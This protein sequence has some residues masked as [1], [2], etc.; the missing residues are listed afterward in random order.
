M[1]QEGHLGFR[2]LA[3]LGFTVLAGVVVLPHPA[4]VAQQGITAGWAVALLSA[5]WAGILTLP[6]VSLMQDFPGRGLPEALQE[7]FGL[8]P[9][10]VA[11][12]ALT[13]WL[14][15][16]T[17]LGVRLVM[18]TFAVA[19]LPRTPPTAIGA[20]VLAM[21]VYGAYLGLEPV[22][23]A[24]VIVWPALTLSVLAVAAAVLPEAHTDWLFPLAGPGLSGLV[25]ASLRDIGLWADLGLTGVYAYAARSPGHLRAAAM[26]ALATSAIALA[27]TVALGT[28]VLGPEDAARHPFLFYRLARLVYLGRFFQRAE[29]LFVLFWIVG[30][31]VY[32]AI[33]LHATA[34]L[35]SVTLALPY[36]RPLLFPL[37]VVAFSISL[38]PPDTITA[39]RADLA[40]RTWA[41]GPVFGVPILAYG[42][43]L[44]RR[45]GVPAHAPT[46]DD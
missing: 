6:I 11:N 40:V 45:K 31:L 17:A 38:L 1:Y 5:V 41:V 25:A 15:L 8:V 26:W 18:E 46:G 2:E 43:R 24:N 27:G 39:L 9:G 37:A 23:R 36:Y 22:A 33:S 14:V 10:L 28:A 21:A 19:I 30:A 16:K 7:T 35:A 44:L 42:L 34:S 32:M 20:T 3:L 4:L 29:G 12:V 13:L